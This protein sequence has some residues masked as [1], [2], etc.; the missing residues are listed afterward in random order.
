MT[1]LYWVKPKINS[2]DNANW[3][4]KQVKKQEQGV[5]NQEIKPEENNQNDIWSK[6]KSPDKKSRY[7]E[8]R[9]RFTHIFQL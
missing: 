8:I 4:T 7:I 3:N 9:F 1:E 6:D 2:E 5:S